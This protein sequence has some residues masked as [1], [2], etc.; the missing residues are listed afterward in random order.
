[1]IKAFVFDL[2]GVIRHWDNPGIVDRAECEHGL[3]KGAI[4]TTAFAEA[5]LADVTTGVISD[6]DWRAEVVRRLEATHPDANAAGAVAAWSAP[7]GDL[8]PGSKEVLE[9][10]RHHGK[11]CLLSNATSRLSSDLES[12][13]IG[14]HFDHIFNSSELGFAKPDPQIFVYIERHLNMRAEEIIYVDDSPV[15][16][17]AAAR[18]GWVSLLASPSNTL[19]SLINVLLDAHQSP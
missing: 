7:S 10:A 5:L 16:V 13:G 17:E 1:M 12:L 6:D 19:S 15:N 8:V 11:V 9:K 18:Q 2:D 4:F 14:G 3:P